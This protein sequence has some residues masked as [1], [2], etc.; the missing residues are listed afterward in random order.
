MTQSGIEDD[1]SDTQQVVLILRLTLDRHAY[2]RHGEL[3]D[4]EASGQG[5]FM[6]LSEMSEAVQQWL[7]RQQGDHFRDN[8][9]A[10]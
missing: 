6:T 10:S 8:G 1:L 3:L 7:D 9:L 2:L 5:R 4:A